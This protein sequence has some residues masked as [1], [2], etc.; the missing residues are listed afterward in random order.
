[1]TDGAPVIVGLSGGVDSAV[2]A[3]LLR[4]R[5]CDVRGLFMKNWE[6]DDKDGYCAAARDLADVEQVCE[7]LSIP[8]HTVNFSTEY[9]DQVFQDFLAELR[10][11]HT[12][13]PD[14]LCNQKIKF[15]AFFEHALRLGGQYI[16]TGHYA[17]IVRSEE[18]ARLYKGMDPSKDQSYFLYTLGQTPLSRTLFPVGGISKSEVRRI[19]RDARLPVHDKKDSTGICFIGERPFKAFLGRYIE[20]CPGDIESPEGQVI[21]RHDGLPFY[22]LGQRQGLGIGG[23]RNAGSEPW[24]VGAKD[25]TRNVLIVVQ[26]RNHPMLYRQTLMAKQLHWVAGAAPRFPLRC[27]AK[28]RYRQQEQNCEVID[29]GDDRCH[30]RFD[31]PQWAVTPGQSVVFYRDDECLGGGIIDSKRHQENSRNG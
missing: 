20:S 11:G 29:V 16:A 26:G 19:A 24:Y 1:M 6:E 5:G 10:Q 9:W 3:L 22:T 25:R 18:G 2:C 31:E 13:N 8:L 7:R 23:R 28:V 14:V 30:I 12:P 21:G 17:N 15:R 4:R 27:R